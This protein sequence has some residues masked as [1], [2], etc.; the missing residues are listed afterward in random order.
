MGLLDDWLPSWAEPQP[1]T[2]KRDP[3][4]LFWLSGKTVDKYFKHKD[5]FFTKASTNQLE[6]TQ[7]QCCETVV[8]GILIWWWPGHVRKGHHLKTEDE[9]KLTQCRCKLLHLL[10]YLYCVHLVQH[11]SHLKRWS[12][13]NYS[14]HMLRDNC[15]PYLASSPKHNVLQLKQSFWKWGN[16]RKMGA[17][18]LLFLQF[19]LE[20]EWNEE[21][22]QFL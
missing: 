6:D 21:W 17:Q 19:Q 14:I 8:L 4:S 18:S 7:S 3:T 2:V 10:L 13:H 20:M 12:K 16:L 5:I 1:L 15:K 11:E 9:S 22:R